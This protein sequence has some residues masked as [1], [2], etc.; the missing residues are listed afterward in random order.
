M[1]FTRVVTKSGLTKLELAALY[2]TSRQT[3]YVWASGR[4][5]HEK[6]PKSRGAVI[7]PPWRFAAITQ[8]LVKLI[9]LRQLPWGALDKAVRRSRITKMSEKLQGLK[10]APVR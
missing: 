10:P 9:D 7:Y 3:I 6:D 2:G 4:Q 5:P 1:N 8:A